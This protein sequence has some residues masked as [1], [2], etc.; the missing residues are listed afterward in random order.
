MLIRA[1]LAYCSTWQ[2]WSQRDCQRTSLSKV[3]RIPTR[4]YQALGLGLGTIYIY[5][6]HLGQYY[7]GCAPGLGDTRH[8][9]TTPLKDEKK[10]GDNLVESLS[11]SVFVCL[12]VYLSVS[13]CLSVCLGGGGAR[14]PSPPGTPLISLG[15]FTY[16][17]QCSLR[18]FCVP[19]EVCCERSY[20]ILA[21]V[22][23]GL[24]WE[25]LL[26]ISVCLWRF[27]LRGP[28]WYYSVCLWRFAVRGPT[29]Y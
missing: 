3:I 16:L 19:F 20:L 23:G 9:F 29:W 24:P 11:Q 6:P 14:P 12:S 18:M 2:R 26:D 21:S 15:Y 7:I 1:D 17:W 5:D 22:S 27:A 4:H 10:L 25:V 8:L 13:V 28:T